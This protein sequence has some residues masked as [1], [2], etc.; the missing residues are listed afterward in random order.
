[1]VMMMMMMMKKRRHED[2]TEGAGD[3]HGDRDGERDGDG[4]GQGGEVVK[5]PGGSCS[6]AVACTS[7]ETCGRGECSDCVQIGWFPIRFCQ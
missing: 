2:T 7:S 5:Y 6:P 4:E 1:M 3:G